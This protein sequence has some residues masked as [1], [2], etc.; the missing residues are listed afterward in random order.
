[1]FLIPSAARDPY[2]LKEITGQRALHMKRISE[3]RRIV[4]TEEFPKH[5]VE[6]AFM[7]AVKDKINR[8]FSP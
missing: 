2:H 3:C 1:L 6:Q 7:P 5:W 4:P 8:A